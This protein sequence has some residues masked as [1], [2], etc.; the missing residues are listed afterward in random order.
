MNY[1]QNSDKVG[2][3]VLGLSGDNQPEQIPS[4][5]ILLNETSAIIGQ[6]LTSSAAF[7]CSL[8]HGGV[9]NASL[10]VYASGVQ[11]TTYANL[12]LQVYKYTISNT[13]TLIAQTGYNVIPYTDTPSLM[14]FTLN[15]PT[16]LSFVS[17][18]RL[19]LRVMGY[20]SYDQ[21][22][23]KPQT[24]YCCFEGVDRCGYTTSTVPVY[25]W[26]DA[27]QNTYLGLSALNAKTTGNNDTAV[28]YHALLQITDDNQNTA[29]GSLAGSNLTSGDNNTLLGY[30]AQA[31]TA[32]SS[33]QIVLGNSAV[34]VLRCQQTSISG[35]SDERDKKDVVDLDS[36]L[37][38]IRRLR[39]VAFTWNS[40]DG[41]RSGDRDMGFIAQEVLK[42]ED[43]EYLR[44]VSSDD[45]ERYEMAPAR[46]IP[47]LVKAV[48]E[49]AARI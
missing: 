31:S 29:I 35:L 5:T 38:F 22:G 23:V 2:Y 32:T 42:Q 3:K 20:N 27:S 45:T 11:S 43:K 33:N 48:Q 47:L 10:Y 40:R 8:F 34:T 44:I 39:P 13:A 14:E 7:D 18:D 1:S 19:K 25:V 9:W 17:S 4:V 26:S 37:E 49:L 41:S 30:N 15:I 21:S 16:N 6:F 28:G 24:I 12:Y 36:G 46:L